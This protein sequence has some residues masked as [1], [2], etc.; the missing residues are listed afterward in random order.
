LLAYKPISTTKK[1]CPLLTRVIK[2]LCCSSVHKA[3]NMLKLFSL[4]SLF[5]CFH[6]FS[7]HVTDSQCT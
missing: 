7:P 3:N 5:V 4:F 2:K 1:L 6:T